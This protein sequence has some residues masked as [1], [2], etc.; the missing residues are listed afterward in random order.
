[1]DRISFLTERVYNIKVSQK[2]FTKIGIED[3][4]FEY[5]KVT[6]KGLI[7]AVVHLQKL[8]DT[9]R[10]ITAACIGNK[11]VLFYEDLDIDFNTS[12]VYW[13]FDNN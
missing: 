13:T 6:A 4:L 12:T 7:I 10:N 1:M 5:H 2:S 8:P 11:H 9:A 3:I